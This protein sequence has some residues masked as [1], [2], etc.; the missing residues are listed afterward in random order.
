MLLA[1]SLVGLAGHACD[2]AVDYAKIREQFGKPIG[3][4]QAIR[5]RC[6]DMGVRQRLSWYQTSLACLKLEA[7]APD[8]PLQIASAML[9][10]AVRPR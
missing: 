4:F 7:G 6:A 3:T 1:A 5:H 2:L 8:A 9:L 10:A